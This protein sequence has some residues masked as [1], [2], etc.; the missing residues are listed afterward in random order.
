MKRIWRWFLAYRA[1]RRSKKIAKLMIACEQ[2]IIKKM[3][4]LAIE[5]YGTW[6]E[7]I[8]KKNTI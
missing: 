2:R 7:S 1:R 5:K 4:K 6:G 8:T 3:E